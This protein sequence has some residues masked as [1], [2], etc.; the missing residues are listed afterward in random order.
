[1]QIREL[2]YWVGSL[3]ANDNIEVINGNTLT[4]TR[5][6]ALIDSLCIGGTSFADYRKQI[7]KEFKQGARPITVGFFKSESAL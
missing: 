3:S 4:A 5:N 7:H 6:G 1:M 2:R